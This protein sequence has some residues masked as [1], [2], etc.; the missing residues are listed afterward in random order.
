MNNFQLRDLRIKLKGHICT[1]VLMVFGVSDQPNLP[2]AMANFS[3][4]NHENHPCSIKRRERGWELSL[5]VMN[6]IR[7]AQESCADSPDANPASIERSELWVDSMMQNHKVQISL[8]ERGQ[9]TTSSDTLICAMLSQ[10]TSLIIIVGSQKKFCTNDAQCEQ[11]SSGEWGYCLWFNRCTC[12][13]L[14]R[15]SH[16]QIGHV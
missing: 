3:H 10:V 14:Y 1:V 7:P 16:G 9:P 13:D 15:I 8:T 5:P 11:S 12:G 2:Y 4:H 6:L